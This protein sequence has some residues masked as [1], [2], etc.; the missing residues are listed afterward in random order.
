M[1]QISD[2]EHD[3]DATY[4]MINQPLDR[5]QSMLIALLSWESKHSIAVGGLAEHATELAAALSKRG[6]VVHLFTRIGPNQSRYDC[7]DGVHYHRC[8]YVGDA[9]FITDNARMCDAFIW[10]MTETENHLQRPFDIVHGHD[11]LAVRAMTQAKDT[12]GRP[13]VMTVHSTEYG[14][15][16]N[17]LYEGQ[18]RR[19]REF[20]WLGAYVAESVICVSGALRRE[21]HDLYGVPVDKMHV[22]YNGIDVTRFDGK[23]D[24]RRVRERHAVPAGDPMVLFAGRLT[25]QKGPDL[26]VE[27]LPGVLGHNPRA[28]FVFA[29]DGDLRG[30]VQQRVGDLGITPATRFVGY[31]SG[32]DLIDLFKTADVVCVPSRNEPFGI[33]I[34][35][36]WSACR[37]VVATRNGGP[38]EFVSHQDTGLIVSDDH[39]S[40]GG[41]LD[42]I[43]ADLPRGMQMGLNGRRRAE[44]AFS[45]D[46]IA[47]DT[48][49]VYQAVL[50]RRSNGRRFQ[51]KSNG[52]VLAD[53]KSSGGSWWEATVAT[54]NIVSRTKPDEQ[55]PAVLEPIGQ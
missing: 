40:I 55:E 48:E 37:P 35:E 44:E 20:E 18:S 1:R 11:W 23:V 16:G 52:V 53:R 54:R 33:V 41:G 21:V 4:S 14:R 50:D 38:A 2:D 46:T 6:H 27:A 12:H 47:T 34:L 31:Q 51:K 30:G 24:T 25:W 36:A 22:I 5:T 29:G 19:I 8:P 17:Q 32:R 49:N 13:V 9:D 26:L 45:W 43:L 42:E 15:C 7:I 39:R 3:V 10:H 28:K